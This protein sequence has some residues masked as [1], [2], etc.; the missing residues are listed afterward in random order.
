[1]GI[2]ATARDTGDVAI[3]VAL[4]AA[5]ASATGSPSSSV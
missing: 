5:I 3:C 1:M 2:V 4:A